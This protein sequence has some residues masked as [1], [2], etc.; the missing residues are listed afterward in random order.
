MKQP[1]DS[2]RGVGRS[3]GTESEPKPVEIFFNQTAILPL[4]GL[5]A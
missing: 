2:N 5:K 3:S 1:K 4:V